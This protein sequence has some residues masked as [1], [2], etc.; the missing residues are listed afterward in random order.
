MHFPEESHMYNLAAEK[1]VIGSFLYESELI[2]DCPLKSEHF[3]DPKHVR[4][5]SAI[6]ELEE[7][8]HPIEVQS[9]YN[10]LGAANVEAVGG[11][12]YLTELAISIPTTTSFT[13]YQGLIVEAYEKRRTH[14]I[15]VTMMQMNAELEPSEV[16]AAAIDELNKLDENGI[17]DEDDGHIKN[18]L[19]KVYDWMEQD[20]GEIT[21]APT[22]FTELD[23]MLS[24]LQ[25]QDLVIIGARPSM[26]KTAFAINIC[27]NYAT[28]ATKGG[29]AGIF[30]LEMPDES[31]A[32]R[33]LSNQGNID[34]QAMRNPMGNFGDADWRK[35]TMAMGSLG[36]APLHLFDKSGVDV[37]Y[38]RKKCRM[39][40]RRYPG[41]HIVVVID[42]LQL[43]VGNP[44][45]GG[46]RTAE[47][48][49]ISRA[50]KHIARELNITVI[51]LSQLSRGVEQRQDKRPMMSDLRESG[52]IEQD[53]DVIGFL[54]R[55]DYYD[56]E[57]EAK[58]II[59][60]IIAKQRNGPV[61]TVN[62]AYVKEYNKFVNLEYRG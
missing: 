12:S 41:E 6:R 62:L 13:F 42:Y 61:G 20:H 35:T 9:V 19:V 48:G 45:H 23:K 8:G 56:K 2:K 10:Q 11:I 54:Y 58:N 31:L 30:S 40:T 18:V 25:R 29:P 49:E 53:A 47:I 38:I 28:A 43:I 24:G 34:A 4:I 37:A 14:D 39:L 44:K 1:T 17:S 27:Q 46:N 60:I 52:Q 32:K 15:A 33:M 21:G 50:L 3:Y 51:A 5:F 22:G 55:D 57:S 7:K 16:R 59:E 36:N 26:G